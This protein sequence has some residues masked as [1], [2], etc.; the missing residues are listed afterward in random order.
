MTRSDD[1]VNGH[2]SPLPRVL[3]AIDIDPSQKYGTLEEQVVELARAFRDRQSLLLPLYRRALG[4]EASAQYDAL[5]LRA[6]SLDMTRFRL[7]RLARLLALI[8][9][10]KIQVV[11]WNFYAPLSNPYLWAIT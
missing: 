8:R 10:E 6:S 1:D 7:A 11:H 4:P 9:R 3:L 5:G 2:E